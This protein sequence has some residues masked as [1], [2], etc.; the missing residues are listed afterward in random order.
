MVWGKSGRAK[1]G[2]AA[3][4]SRGWE[5]SLPAPPL[6]PGSYGDQPGHQV[7]A[8]PLSGPV[9]AVLSA[10]LSALIAAAVSTIVSRRRRR[11]GSSGGCRGGHKIPR[12][13]RG[14]ASEVDDFSWLRPWLELRVLVRG[15]GGGH[16]RTF[17]AHSVRAAGSRPLLRPPRT[18]FRRLPRSGTAIASAAA[19]TWHKGAATN[20]GGD[21]AGLGGAAGRV[22]EHASGHAFGQP[23]PPSSNLSRAARRALQRARRCCSRGVDLRPS[24]LEH[25][26]PQRLP[27]LCRPDPV[28][29][30]RHQRPRPADCCRWRRGPGAHGARD[31]R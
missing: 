17:P 28:L 7:H 25:R 14:S 16:H 15:A 4:V 21:G 13:A 6:Q 30:L 24:L 26:L 11:S 29:A 12:A 18:A 27:S 19:A 20:G 1:V 22:P 31:R 3:I 23:L 5:G 9:N 8:F 10:L 2:L